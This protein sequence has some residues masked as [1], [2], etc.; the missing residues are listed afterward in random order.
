MFKS[1]IRVLLMLTVL[2]CSLTSCKTLRGRNAGAQTSSL[3]EPNRSNVT[4]DAPDGPASS[5]SAGSQ[6]SYGQ[7]VV[8]DEV[9][10]GLQGDGQ[11]TA[12]AQ[13]IYSNIPATAVSGQQRSDASAS[14][15]TRANETR[16]GGSVAAKA[17]SG[18][19]SKRSTNVVPAATSNVVST[20][21]TTATSGSRNAAADRSNQT[22][23]DDEQKA[24]ESQS[25]L[26]ALQDSA[27]VQDTASTMAAAEQPS[28]KVSEAGIFEDADK[29]DGESSSSNMKIL[30]IA[31][32]VI[33]LL[34]IAY[35][36]YTRRRLQQMKKEQEEALLDLRYK[37]YKS[38]HRTE[39]DVQR[40]VQEKVNAAVA[41]L[42]KEKESA[43]LAREDAERELREAYAAREAAERKAS[44]EAMAELAEK[45]KALADLNASLDA[46]ENEIAE[47][48]NALAEK[49]TQMAAQFDSL[50]ERDENLDARRAELENRASAMDER[51]KELA[52]K[53]EQLAEKVA[54]LAERS[55]E[56]DAKSAEL[57]AKDAELQAAMQ[58]MQNLSAVAVAQE[59]E[60]DESSRSAAINSM[61]KMLIRKIESAQTVL[62]L[63]GEKKGEV[64]TKDEWKDIEN[65]LESADGGFVSRLK[66]KCPSLTAK[67]IELM[68]LLR[69]RIPSKNIASVYGI[70]EKSIKQKLFV[71]KTKVGLE[72][73]TMSL[74]DYIEN[75]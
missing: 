31:L 39:A 55:A 60:R 62:D 48:Q 37:H 71:Y 29:E 46:K 13:E 74:R 12:P 23:T 53:D 66:E 64:L 27:A 43:I 21:A 33:L 25:E 17:A 1:G 5:A 70:N 73:D 20:P 50:K 35:I 44:A 54:Q 4:Q 18:N 51:E 65:F 68:L 61:R 42:E 10:V 56:L 36:I 63:K 26:T 75:L 38:G 57:E 24:G 52:A 22:S 59:P 69:L 2:G 72:S 34:F 15:E 45:E 49:E 32:V 40:E 67:D 7:P 3:Y 9:S 47:R 8:L 19:A 41:E 6:A 58:E 11:S 30:V 28:I 14:S 16:K